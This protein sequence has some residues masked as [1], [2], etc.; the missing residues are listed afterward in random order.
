[1]KKKFII[2]GAISVVVIAAIVVAILLLTC[3]KITITFDT[4]GAKEVSAIEIKKGES[5][6]LP[7]VEKAGFI[8][9]G[10]Y[11][12]GVKVIDSTKKI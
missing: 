6:K 4:D 5:V 8:L 10:W 3:K 1:M 2:I 11:L 12:N 7:E 9:E